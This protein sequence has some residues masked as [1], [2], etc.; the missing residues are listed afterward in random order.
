MLTGGVGDHGAL[1][2]LAVERDLLHTLLGTIRMDG[3]LVISLAELTANGVVGG[4]LRETG[5]DADTVVVGLD[6]EDNS[7]T[8]SPETAP[9]VIKNAACDQSPSVV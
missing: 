9:A 2:G 1:Y 3:D 8:T 4:R 6:A 5:V 7:T